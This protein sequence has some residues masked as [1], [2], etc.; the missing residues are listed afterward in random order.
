MAETKLPVQPYDK[1]D[2]LAI[3]NGG[4]VQG[5]ID[6]KQLHL[7]PIPSDADSKTY[8]LKIVNGVL[9]WVEEA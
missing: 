6:D 2:I 3:V 7:P 1:D 8:V 4:F 5:K 9:D